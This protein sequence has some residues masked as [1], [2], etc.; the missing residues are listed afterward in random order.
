MKLGHRTSPY[1]FP[2]LR[3]HFETLLATISHPPFI[4]CMFGLIFRHEELAVDSLLVGPAALR[5]HN[6]H[7][8]IRV[9][10]KQ[11]SEKEESGKAGLDQDVRKA[12]GQLTKLYRSLREVDIVLTLGAK[13]FP[14]GNL[15]R[16]ALERELRGD[17]SGAF[18]TYEGALDALEKREVVGTV[19]VEADLTRH[20]KYRSGNAVAWRCSASWATGTLCGSLLMAT[21][22]TQS[23]RIRTSA[24]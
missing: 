1:P 14:E 3:A 6:D 7:L 12:Q 23:S 24:C 9:L 5:S 22:R 16:E 2:Q 21:W 4:A 18:R 19:E 15:T 17:Y 8:G 10:E 20:R 11:I 13:Q